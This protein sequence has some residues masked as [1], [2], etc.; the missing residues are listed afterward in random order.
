MVTVGTWNVENLFRPG[1]DSGP[2]SDDEYDRKL[3]ALAATIADA[4]VD[5]LAVQEVGGA[6]ELDDLAGRLDGDWSTVLSQEPDGR[7]IRVGFLSRLP[8][9]D[10]VDVVEVPAA[11]AGGRIDDDGTV[12][13]RVGRGALQVEVTADGDELTLVTCHLKSK[14]LSYPGGR[15]EPRDRG[16]TRPVRRVRA[17][18]PGGGGGRPSASTPTASD[19]DG[20]D[21]PLVV[22]GDLNDTPDAATTQLLLGP[23]GSEIG[24]PG[25]LRPPTR[26]TVGG[27]G[28][29]RPESRRAPGQAAST[30]DAAS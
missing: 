13:T 25:E 3:T 1:G 12:L 26:A 2:R 28:T 29:S 16:R 10:P 23:G 27:S 15:F 5:V 19:G 18:P 22:L 14:L 7:G 17:E 30:A 9:A 6:D 24:T 11:L 21:R 20:A 8:L 4:A